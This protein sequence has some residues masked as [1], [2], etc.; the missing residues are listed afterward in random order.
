[1]GKWLVYEMTDHLGIIIKTDWQ[2]CTQEKYM[3]F[4]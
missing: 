2:P 4:G 3:T 1:M